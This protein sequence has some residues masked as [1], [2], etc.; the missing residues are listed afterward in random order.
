MIRRSIAAC[1]LAVITV[2]L[3]AFADAPIGGILLGSPVAAIVRTAGTPGSVESADS[4][5]R[6]TF[7]TATAYADDDGMVRALDVSTG[8]V[9]VEVDGKPK[10]FSIG[11]YTY[12]RA[13]AE[14]ANFAEFS[15]DS[16]RTYI[17]SPTRELVLMFDAA[18][19]LS[20][21][22]Y[23]ERGPLA[24]LG[25]IPGEDGAKT[26]PYKAP[27]VRHSALADGSGARITI[28]KLRVDRTGNV[29]DVEV[30]VPSTDSP[31]DERVVK[32]L[33][34]DRFT[35]ATLGGRAIGATVFRELRH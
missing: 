1:S 32:Q 28:V 27:K 8:D 19:K 29:T 20:R 10:T 33:A 4:G 25:V 3:A 7:P 21:V 15:N 23:G 9:R 17:L 6:F 35:P 26:F 14:L 5:N 18:K 13:E 30:L 31:F 11:T 12:A 22:I 34:T 16:T 24:R 2:P